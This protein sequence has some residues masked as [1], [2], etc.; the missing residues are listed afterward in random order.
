[1]PSKM[2]E[3]STFPTNS[4]SSRRIARRCGW[5]NSRAGPKGAASRSSLP[6]AGGAAHLPG[7]GRGAYGAAGARRARCR[8]RRCRDSTRCSRSSRCR[9]AC[10]WARW[11]SASRAR[12]TR[13]CWRCPSC[14][15]R[16]P[17]CARSCARFASRRRRQEGPP[18]IVHRRASARHRAGRGARCARQRP[19][20]AHVHHRRPANGLPRPHLLSGRGHADRSGRRRRGDGALRGPRRAAGLREGRSP[21]SPSNSRTCRVTPCM[22]I[23]GLVP[24][25]PSGAALHIAQ[26]RAREKAFL[27]E[28]GFPTVP[29]ARATHWTNCGTAWRASARPPSSR[30]RRSA[31]TARGSTRSRR[32]ADVEHIWTALNGQ[33]GRGREVRL[34][35]GGDLGDRGAR[36]RRRGCRISA[37]RESP[38]QSHPRCDDG[39]GGRSAADGVACASR[40]P[41]R[42]WRR[43]TTSASCAS[44]SL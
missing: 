44:S 40:S 15:I 5:R 21:S 1:M 22:R 12:P 18:V 4:T 9:A 39:A 43:S 25:R 23:D 32:P 33:R 16:V 38:Q 24:V 31:T 27:A 7:D 17:I 13:A 36:S 41:A 2:L 34:A 26:Q 35:A 10:P 6:G 30:R 14:R 11:R 8:A 19:A 37:V 42:F 28:R 29:F 3:R 20:R